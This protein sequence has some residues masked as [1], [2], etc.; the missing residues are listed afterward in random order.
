MSELKPIERDALRQEIHDLLPAP[1]RGETQLDGVDVLVGGDP[2]EVIVRISGGKVAV[3]SYSARWQGPCTLVVCPKRVGTL[4]WKRLPAS[5]TVILIHIL[6]ESAAE[7]RRAGFRTCQR[8]N[9]IQPP[10][11]MHGDGICQSCAQ[12]HLGVVY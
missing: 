2:G 8:C 3:Y 10:E 1:V 4:N 5:R 6:I 12:E 9:R 11:F 7:I